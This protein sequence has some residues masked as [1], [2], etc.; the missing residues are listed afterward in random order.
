MFSP[1]EYPLDED[2][3]DPWA[4]TCEVFPDN[5]I[6]ESLK[7]HSK[8]VDIA[9]T[10]DTP[11]VFP[12]QPILFSDLTDLKG[13]VM[14][15]VPM[16]TPWPTG[17]PDDQPIIYSNSCTIPEETNYYNFFP[18]IPGS[19]KSLWDY[20]SNDIMNSY[21]FKDCVPM[22]NNYRAYAYAAYAP[23]GY[24]M[25]EVS[26]K[27]LVTTKS[28]HYLCNIII[29][30][31]G[32]TPDVEIL[33]VTAIQSNDNASSPSQARQYIV[34][35]DIE[36]QCSVKEPCRFTAFFFIPSNSPIPEPTL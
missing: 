2:S 16:P 23:S 25:F 9:K 14:T 31:P 24:Q 10:L 36:F 13:Y 8:A 11:F 4:I 6:D 5:S 17:T 22:P 32:G 1:A 29:C 34:T 3:Q 20:F 26:W 33:Y 27:N 28:E 21:K 15:N 30:L 35:P 12:K 18:T 7:S 19:P